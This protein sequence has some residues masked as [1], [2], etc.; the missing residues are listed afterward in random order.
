MNKTNLQNLLLLEQDAKSFGFDWPNENEIIEQA[1]NECH[2]IREAIKAQEAPERIQE[3][4]GDL[5]HA[6][7][8]LCVFTGFDVE[9]TL[10]LVNKKFG[11]R[12]QALKKLTHESGLANLHGQSF[13]KLMEFW[14]EAK[15]EAYKS[16]PLRST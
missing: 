5:L 12:M 16:G 1:I 13:E 2:E 15:I 9:E 11:S 7:I 6:V 3:E 14:R 8:S 4:I 10:A